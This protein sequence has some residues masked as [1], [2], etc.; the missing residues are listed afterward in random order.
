MEK[1]KRLPIGYEDFSEIR[2]EEFYYVDKTGLI[3]ELLETPGKVTL[4]TRPRRFGKTLNMSMLRYFFE[5]GSDEALFDG[6]KIAENEEL[7]KRYMGQY[8][9]ISISL[10]G[11]QAADFETAKGMLRIIIS[12][13]AERLQRAMQWDDLS[14]LQQ[15]DIRRLMERRM[16]DDAL[17]DSL[18]RLSDI[19][20]QYYGKKTVIL[21]D[22]Y[23]V[24]LDKAFENGYYDQMVTLIRNLLAQ[25]LK[26]NESLQ[27]A[28]LTGCLRIAKESFFTGLNN[29][30]V[31]SVR[32]VRYDEYFGFTDGEVR[33][34]LDY[35][36]LAEYYEAARRWYDG[37]RFGNTDVYC[38]W[39]DPGLVVSHARKV[40][41]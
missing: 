32:D 22:E 29:F 8:P 21:I 35:Y 13:E 6:L 19:L 41:G 34:M 14:A 25:A 28:V 12:R 10:K 40:E 26:T 39:W 11:V 33:A 20:H 38:P 9:V 5:V 3:E 1:K 37:Y 27:L 36:G 18:Q 4:F 7:C 16:D 30:K 15:E 23:D 2:T 24:P 31:F 17:M